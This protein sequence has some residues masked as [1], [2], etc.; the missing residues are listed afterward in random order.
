ME[1]AIGLV[2]FKPV[3]LNYRAMGTSTNKL[4]EYAARGI[5]VVV[6]DTPSFHRALGE[7][8]WAG[9][10][11][12]EQPDSIAREIGRFL[13]D[14]NRYERACRAARQA[15]EQRYNF[16]R[17]MPNVLERLISLAQ[18]DSSRFS[19]S[20]TP[21]TRSGIGGKAADLTGQPERP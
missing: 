12:L 14:R 21:Q 2:L 9:Y 13:A 8:E 3:S 10:A 16:E 1:A 6:P 15:F 11:D 7:E 19:T 20:S 4:Y 5:P 18:P 17:V